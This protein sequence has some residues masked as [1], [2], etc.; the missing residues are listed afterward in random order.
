MQILSIVKANA[1]FMFQVGSGKKLTVYYNYSVKNM[2]Q[3][4]F[5]CC[6]TIAFLLNFSG[7]I[8]VCPTMWNECWFK[9]DTNFTVQ[10]HDYDGKRKLYSG[11]KVKNWLLLGPYYVTLTM[12][13]PGE[14][15][16]KHVYGS[17]YKGRTFYMSD[18][19][20]GPISR[21]NQKEAEKRRERE[22]Q[23]EEQRRQE[24]AR[25]RAEEQRRQE[26]ACRRAEEQRR[27]EEARR[28]AEERRHQE[29]ARRRAEEQRRQEEARR[30]AEEQRRQ[31]EAR[32]RA[33][34]QRRQEEARRRAEEQRRQEEARRRAE[35]Q[36][37]QEEARRR[38]EE[39]RRQEEARRRAEEQRRQEEARRRAEEQRR[40]E[41]AERKRLEALRY[42]E[43]LRQAEQERLETQRLLEE[44]R[45]EQ[46]RKQAQLKEDLFKKAE[47][48]WKQG[49]EQR[50]LEKQKKEAERLQ[51]ELEQKEA[52]RKKEEEWKAIRRK[53]ADAKKKREREE[54][55]KVAEI[56]QTEKDKVS[57]AREKLKRSDKKHSASANQMQKEQ[58]SKR[59]TELFEIQKKM[60]AAKSKR[61]REGT[62][63]EEV[64][65]E[66]AKDTEL[67]AIQKRMAGLKS[68]Q[69]TAQKVERQQS[70]RD[71]VKKDSE[72][73]AIHKRMAEAKL[74]RER[75][76]AE[77]EAKQKQ[78]EEE[79]ERET[80]LTAVR[81]RMAES[82][83]KRERQETAEK[84]ERQ[85]LVKEEDNELSAVH[86]R[87]AEAKS[88]RERE[89][90][91]KEA[92][93]QRLVERQL[94]EETERKAI[95]KKFAEAGKKRR[96]EEAK[97]GAVVQKLTEEEEK[98]LKTREKEREILA[99]EEKEIERKCRDKERALK[100]SKGNKLCSTREYSARAE[101]EED[102]TY[103]SNDSLQLL[104][105]NKQEV[106]Q[107]QLQDVNS[108]VFEENSDNP[109]HYGTE[110]SS[111][112]ITDE[113]DDAPLFE[114]ILNMDDTESEIDQDWLMQAQ[115]FSLF[116]FSELK[117]LKEAHLS[118][119]LYR[120]SS[121]ASTLSE[122][123]FLRFTKSLAALNLL[124]DDQY[125]LNDEDGAFFLRGLLYVSGVERGFFKGASDSIGAN[126]DIMAV[127]NDDLSDFVPYF[128]KAS[129]QQLL[130]FIS[131]S[132]SI[133]V[134][135]NQ[136]TTL[137]SRVQMYQLPLYLIEDAIIR[138][139]PSLVIER[140]MTFQRSAKDL[141]QLIEELSKSKL[142]SAEDPLP[143]QLTL[144][145]DC[146]SSKELQNVK[147]WKKEDVPALKRALSRIAD[148]ATS[149][150]DLVSN[151]SYALGCLSSAIDLSMKIKPRQ[152]QLI[153]L[154]VL[155]LSQQQ[156]LNRLLEVLTG[157]G[158][159][160]IIAMYA[161]ALALQGKKVD[162]VTSSP[163]LAKRDAS[164][165]TRFYHLFGLRATDNTELSIDQL[166][167]S[168]V[169]ADSNRCYV[170]E[171][172][173]VYGT[174][175]SF[176]GDI[177]RQEFEKRH[178]RGCRRYEAAIIDEVDMLMMDEGVQFTYLSHRLALLRH[179]EPVLALV[180]SAVHPHS[181]LA[182]EDGDILFAE[183]PKP[184]NTVV[185]GSVDSDKY[186]ELKEIVSEPI[187]TQE[188]MIS[189]I[190]CINNSKAS[191]IKAYTL[192]QESTLMQVSESESK[193]E[194]LSILLSDNG[195][196]H[197]LYTQDKLTEGV[198]NMVLSQCTASLPD[199][200]FTQSGTPYHPGQP[201]T[202]NSIL[203]E[204]LSKLDSQCGS[205]LVRLLEEGVK[206]T[207]IQNVLASTDH[208]SKMVALEC[209]KIHHVT[210]FLQHLNEQQVVFS[211]SAFVMDGDR[212][213]EVITAN[214]KTKVLVLVADKGV[215]HPLYTMEEANMIQE[216][217]FC[218]PT[219]ESFYRGIPNSVD[220]AA[221]KHL[222]PQQ[223]ILF[224]VN[225]ANR[226]FS[227]RQV[228]QDAE[229]FHESHI[230]AVLEFLGEK[231]P[232]QFSA[233]KMSPVNEREI[234]SCK[235]KPAAGQQLQEHDTAL[236]VL[237]KG[238][239]RLC[240]LHDLEGTDHNESQEVLHVRHE[241]RKVLPGRVDLF[242]KVLCAEIGSLLL[243]MIMNDN[244]QNRSIMKK[245]TSARE[246]GKEIPERDV[247]EAL[248]CYERHLNNKLVVYGTDGKPREPFHNTNQ[249]EDISL[250]LLDNGDICK[251]QEKDP[252]AV[253]ASLKTF[254]TSQLSTYIDSA[255]T[256]H[257]MV[258]NREYLIS[259]D[260]KIIPVDFENSGIIEANK[261]WGGGLQQMLEMKHQLQLSPMSVVTNFL[262]HV[263]FFTR[264]GTGS[265]FGLSGTIG[266]DSDF[267]VLNEL[268][269]FFPCR[270][271]TFSHRLLYERDAVF[272]E[273]DRARWLDEIHNALKEVTSP[274][275][276]MRGAAALVLCE[277]IRTAEEITQH[278]RKKQ[279]NVFVYTRNDLAEEEQFDQE[280]EMGSRDIIVAT[281]LAG[282]GTDVKLTADV[283][284]SGGLF[285]L[286][287][288][289]PKNRRVELQAFGR[290]ARK[291]YPG[292]VQ[293]VLQNYV[294]SAEHHPMVQLNAMRSARERDEVVR[295]EQMIETDVKEVKLREKLFTKHCEFLNVL[296]SNLGERNDATMVIDAVNESW[297]QWL[298]SNHQAITLLR[299]DMLTH[300]L[301]SAHRQWRPDRPGLKPELGSLT[302]SHLPEC[303]YYQLVKFG[304]KCM[305]RLGSQV[306]DENK[307][308]KEQAYHYY[309]KAIRMET[310][311]TM[312]AYYNR[313]CCTLA[314]AK[315]Q[316]MQQSISDL[317]M[318]KELLKVYE[319]E[320]SSI[321][322]LT[323][324]SGRTSQ[325]HEENDFVRQMEVRMQVIKFFESQIDES[326]EQLNKLKS[327][328]EGAIPVP[329]RVLEFIPEA[330]AMTNEE[331]YNLKLLGLEMCFTVEKKPRFSW[332][333]LGVFLLGLA[334]IVA[335]VCLAVLTTGAMA[336]F[337]MGLISE[338][339]SDVID[340]TI[341]MITGE[342]DLKEWAISK[343]CS[344]AI[345]I[346]V[347]GV[348]KFISKGAKAVKGV[349]KDVKVMSKVLKGSTGNALKSGFKV[350]GK[351]AAK[352]LVSQGIMYG[353]GKLENMAIE[354]I[355]TSIGE[356][357]KSQYQSSFQDS[358]NSSSSSKL[359]YYVDHYFSVSRHEAICFFESAATDT[360]QRLLNRDSSTATQVSEFFRDRL[361]PGLT[362]KLKGKASVFKI[363][364]LP[365]VLQ[366]ID[367]AVRK[368]DQVMGTFQR[369]M[370]NSCKKLA[371][372]L[373]E[374]TLTADDRR[375]R[376]DD[377]QALKNDLTEQT[378]QKLGEAVATVLQQNLTWIMNRGLS[379]SV[380]KVA[381][382][383]AG[384]VLNIGGTT[385]EIMDRQKLN[386]VCYMPPRRAK[387][388][389][390]PHMRG[391]AEII[392]NPKTPGTVSELKVVVEK[393]K[394]KVVIEDTHGKKIRSMEPY[395]GQKE[396][397][398]VLV[399]LPPDGNHPLGHY[400]LKAGGQRVKVRSDNNSCMFEALAKGLHHE[401][402]TKYDSDGVRNLVSN[403]ISRR[404]L[405]WHDHFQR[406]E[407]LQQ[408]KDGKLH[409]L[410]GG[411]N[412]RV[413][414]G[415][416]IKPRSY[417]RKLKSECVEDISYEQ[418]NGLKVKA[419]VSYDKKP[420]GV[421][422]TQNVALVGRRDVLRVTNDI[423]VK[424][425]VVQAENCNFEK[426]KGARC[427]QTQPSH[428]QL[429]FSMASRTNDGSAPVSFHI[430]PSEAGAN[431]GIPYGNSVVSS[432][433]YNRQEGEIRKQ[434]R[435]FTGGGNFTCKATVTCEPLIPPK[436]DVGPVIDEYNKSV[437]KQ[438]QSLKPDKQRSTIPK[439][440]AWKVKERF[441]R[442]GKISSPNAPSLS[443][444]Q[445]QRIKKVEWEVT[446]V[447]S[448]GGEETRV[449]SL[450]RDV[451]LYMHSDLTGAYDSTHN[452]NADLD[453]AKPS[454]A[455]VNIGVSS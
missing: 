381:G 213:K 129:L 271:P 408:A 176:S 172:D 224:L 434:I 326:I 41:E 71:E 153:C 307:G 66:V 358:F 164:N 205:T 395:S 190:D 183:I 386:F 193:E 255:I 328:N 127:S 333:A 301:A 331:L 446:K 351:L 313:A 29:E 185:L 329:H 250:L 298:Q 148:K 317:E 247:L 306:I 159:S 311:F 67:T 291:G 21:H 196:V 340:G 384:K 324:F 424:K 34:E 191:H 174:V 356:R 18:L 240:I 142:L 179:I 310:K 449:L 261:R 322:Q 106:V 149:E 330:D 293:C 14:S 192:S 58:K 442:V 86:K 195:K 74:R 390:I 144:I 16:T 15:P 123:Q 258:E 281:N 216:E 344:I 166:N 162:I 56:V 417:Q 323:K 201:G 209:L 39:Q 242:H 225:R 186:P 416:S 140:L 297:G 253:P 124:F 114:V 165:W 111:S 368:L 83:S 379:M 334:Q 200:L 131:Q 24:E 285:C 363:L 418:A 392:R 215:L 355:F 327:D 441:E 130:S 147:K 267:K 299:E 72:L 73:S 325:K 2:E 269:S 448:Q 382:G 238:D 210:S 273:G 278:L 272:A 406:K 367:E 118:Q 335:G 251:L 259:K 264:Y 353:L 125:H 366:S 315:D 146:L 98:E 3:S 380:N 393:L 270:I 134:D 217:V 305:L 31:E 19:F 234:L 61:E 97:K 35:E 295:L 13:L 32:R 239:G 143:N 275:F 113:D 445:A 90:A 20:S 364:E 202:F 257:L 452:Y 223:L 286:L 156:G 171:H 402:H 438:N 168:P 194:P 48:D 245:L 121:T 105:S 419:E 292:C 420:T 284:A 26:E 204:S 175:G 430:I 214:T 60:A 394:C 444:P 51:Q 42:Q 252:I 116:H 401:G 62:K 11:D 391:H 321:S 181:T 4:S 167:L 342:F 230:L 383:L 93:H 178:V 436:G 290:T 370:L 398:V 108:P 5:Q 109:V 369:E 78:V 219:G 341:G 359:G 287:T 120:V 316:Y 92:K 447:N 377:I 248:K 256:A 414:K 387:N 137:I 282:R 53:A 268:Y 128:T 347:G 17:D 222:D 155:L 79:T 226:I 374:C 375:T 304:N 336:S 9:N 27:Q 152:V 177:L 100:Q 345:S 396:A 57:A 69:A 157:E 232:C 262:S 237:M 206:Q 38:A 112:D 182:T 254:V 280:R 115:T 425:I 65:E 276:G 43:K 233:Y 88:R 30:R 94:R 211:V 454:R 314:L 432:E 435:D 346:V 150:S 312:I 84:A 221:S 453:N 343:A 151:L 319:A 95:L 450:G 212:M 68:R 122:Q 110:Q 241:D 184:F 189:V 180:W 365:F 70:E 231:I 357:V 36:R 362:A 107:I 54:A 22:R 389:D 136:L 235:L 263:G 294:T 300:E 439:K 260:K 81:K 318:A 409:L 411:A 187:T 117:S 302:L 80:E 266:T 227:P 337:G 119:L 352:E 52:A 354:K 188:S 274:K 422:T 371:K 220:V 76:E 404:P 277:D 440:M 455:R 103:Q 236:S 303:S 163:V 91:E 126:V 410:E 145:L 265:L 82:K 203:S 160:C 87:M 89:E 332:E 421:P 197:R 373:T 33:E 289:L 309:S 350:A 46:K 433:A 59:E 397:K 25:K 102:V 405:L 229:Q 399:F 99:K 77:K 388:V 400:E 228:T 40:Q 415:T 288:F 28:R 7:S 413:N 246:Q 10:I 12:W 339:V 199:V 412:R 44:K 308:T 104:P 360:I 428:K 6:Y 320:V 243:S 37:R 1:N 378:P 132:N 403:E 45:E 47:E 139:N 348:G 154:C 279:H 85:Q 451:H 49:A 173:I 429:S 75:E 431:A 198:K 170:Y 427:M 349:V 208:K 426:N 372:D 407:H 207:E 133:S 8:K 443:V 101:K 296:R 244:P 423:N 50:K 135:E 338:G 138:C 63:R 141:E 64:E 158:K 169:E 385:K 23:A 96:K 55:K 161:A 361:L 218:T 283:N 437:K 376:Q 249:K